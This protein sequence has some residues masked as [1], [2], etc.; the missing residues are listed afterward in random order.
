VGKKNIR[1]KLQEIK[2]AGRKRKRKKILNR[3]DGREEKGRISKGR[4]SQY[5]GE[6]DALTCRPCLSTICHTHTQT[7]GVG[8]SPV[9]GI[10]RDD[11]D[12]DQ[13]SGS[14]PFKST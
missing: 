14:S 7:G 8:G 12:D 1:L 6:S 10:N 3:N 4:E 5:F 2:S 9:V 13:Q 11:D